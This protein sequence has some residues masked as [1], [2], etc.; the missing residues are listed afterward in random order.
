MIRLKRFSS[1]AIIICCSIALAACGSRAPAPEDGHSIRFSNEAP[2]YRYGYGYGGSR[3]AARQQA[4]ADIASG[5]LTFIRHEQIQEMRSSDSGVEAGQLISTEQVETEYRSVL[6]SLTQVVLPDVEVVEERFTQGSWVVQ[7]RLPDQQ[8][9]IVRQQIRQ[10]LPVLVE[11]DRLES[12]PNSDLSARLKRGVT[13]WRL[14][15]QR[16][17]LGDLVFQEDGSVSTFEAYFRSEAQENAARLRLITEIE[18]QAVRWVVIDSET[19]RPQESIDIK[20][21]SHS[22]KTNRDGLTESLD[23]DSLG[24]AVPVTLYLEDMPQGYLPSHQLHI[25]TVRPREWVN[26]DTITVYVYSEPERQTFNLQGQDYTTPA[27]LTLPRRTNLSAHLYGGEEFGSIRYDNLQV[28]PISPEVFID[29]RPRKREFGELVLS[30][31]DSAATI[32]VAG[33]SLEG[34]SEVSGSV[35]AG[36]YEVTISKPGSRY[37][38]V[39]DKVLIT[40]GERTTRQYRSPAYREPY[41]QG[42]IWTF[43]LFS[44]GGEL[45]EGYNVPGSQGQVTLNDFLATEPSVTGLEEDEFNVQLG[46][47]ARYF[48]NRYEIPVTLSAGVAG[49]VHSV[50]L[51]YDYG[52]GVSGEVEG[53]LQIFE[54]SSGIGLWHPISLT[55]QS[56]VVSWASVNIAYDR[57]EWSQE[58]SDSSFDFP[59]GTAETVHAYAEIGMQ[60]RLGNLT[61]RVPLSDNGRAPMVTLGVGFSEL[62]RGHR[63][64]SSTRAIDGVHY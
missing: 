9:A 45:R 36:Q 17:V 13:G 59:S 32:S 31:G 53:A 64:S 63:L 60:L 30:V 49:R 41:H 40:A 28:D 33:S 26:T 5:I 24:R 14:A 12:I 44:W 43:S 58:D 18:D 62:S 47:Y 52:N 54:A 11:I 22:L 35:E 15:Q 29:F 51:Q 61:A 7:V 20:A 8:M 34:R 50:D 23:I 19:L 48:H 6:T 25:D 39:H 56:E 27:T 1:L 21:G 3:D 38:R 57:A 37:Q 46:M 10:Q 16:G 42:I 55:P 4:L 2:G